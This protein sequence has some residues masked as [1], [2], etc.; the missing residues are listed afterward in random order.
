MKGD[1]RFLQIEINI[2]KKEEKE[3]ENNSGEIGKTIMAKLK[4]DPY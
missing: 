1:T 2:L 4:R 3:M